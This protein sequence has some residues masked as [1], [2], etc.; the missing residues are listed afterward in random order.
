MSRARRR[1][2]AGLGLAAIVLAGGCQEVRELLGMEPAGGE[3][4]DTGDAEPKPLSRAEYAQALQNGKREATRLLEPGAEPRSLI[5]PPIAVGD[6]I[7]AAIGSRHHETITDKT[8]TP[9]VF[10]SEVQVQMRLSRVREAA[11]LTEREYGPSVDEL[12]VT[13]ELTSVEGTLKDLHKRGTEGT[14]DL[15]VFGQPWLVLFDLSG[16]GERDRAWQLEVDRWLWMV[17]PPI[18]N[19]PVGVGARWT[20]KWERY[21][22]R[23]A[24]HKQL[25]S[26]TFTLVSLDPDKAVINAEGT[27][28]I[29]GTDTKGTFDGTMTLDRTR[30]TTPTADWTLTSSATAEGPRGT[31]QRNAEITI[32]VRPVP[33]G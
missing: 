3:P 6:S 13:I 30:R 18:P 33:A 31:A 16:F 4:A 11:T 26:L 25:E 24:E 23:D 15:G 17:M 12:P 29:T 21:A 32:T 22:D 7:E 20:A 5:V 8:P 10:D 1:G 9:F 2:V 19:E 14:T 28:E 27:I